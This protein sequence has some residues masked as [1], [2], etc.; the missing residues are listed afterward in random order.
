MS[1]SK[2]TKLQVMARALEKSA[3][4]AKRRADSMRMHC[5]FD[6]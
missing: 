3:T 1:K 5:R 6:L 2:M 4:A